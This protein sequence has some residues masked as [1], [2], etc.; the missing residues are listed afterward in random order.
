[1]GGCQLPK[2]KRSKRENHAGL[3]SFKKNNLFY[4]FKKSIPLWHN[5]KA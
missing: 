3:K 1:M 4:K 5:P 2:E